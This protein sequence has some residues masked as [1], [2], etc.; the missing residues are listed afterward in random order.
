MNYFEL[1]GRFFFQKQRALLLLALFV[2][3]FFLIFYILTIRLVSLVRLEET[4]DSAALRGKSALEKRANKEKFLQRYTHFEPY[5]LNQH[6]ETLSLLRHELTELTR[7]KRH[8]ACQNRDQLNKRI[9]FIENKENRL[10]FAEESMLS[11]KRVK[12]TEEKLL[13]PVQ[14]DAY[15]L[16]QLLCFIEGIP[17]GSYTPHPHSPQLLIRDFLL[18]SRGNATYELDLNLIKREFS[19]PHENTNL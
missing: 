6:L 1:I 8:P 12:E 11:T 2:T 4:F 9:A 5:F 15:D 3:P 17:I 18:K 19:T 14:I 7:L 10:S 16:D 13:H